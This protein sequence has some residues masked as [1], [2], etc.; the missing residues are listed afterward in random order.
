M[1]VCILSFVFFLARCLFAL[2]FN[3]MNRLSKKCDSKYRTSSFVCL[4]EGE[5]H[6][7][8]LFDIYSNQILPFCMIM[9]TYFA[10]E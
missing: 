4:D 7:N 8:I 10:V 3:Q 6:G 1:R 9:Y 2:L 5:K